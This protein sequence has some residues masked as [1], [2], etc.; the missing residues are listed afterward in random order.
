MKPR[1][2]LGITTY[3]DLRSTE[4]AEQIYDAF[5]AASPKLAPNRISVWLQHQPVANRSDFA[6]HWHTQMAYEIRASRSKTAPIRDEGNS[7]VGANWRTTGALNG[8]GEVSFQPDRDKTRPDT[9]RIDHAFSPRVDWYELLHQLV[10]IT[11]P[12]YAMLHVFNVE[13]TSCGHSIAP[14]EFSGALTGEDRFVSWKTPAGTWRK[15]DKWERAERRRYRYL[16]N[17]P[18]ANY[19]GPEFRD[20]FNLDQLREAVSDSCEMGDGMLFRTTSQL[21]DVLQAEFE[22]S[23]RQAQL[24]RAFAEGTFIGSDHGTP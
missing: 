16:P 18:W 17:L 6:K 8:R 7:Q 24:K 4:I 19:L 11:E 9:L 5:S 21:G 3:R 12:A 10:Q 15:P 23:E 22:F 1:I 14:D 20:S 13:G 2:V